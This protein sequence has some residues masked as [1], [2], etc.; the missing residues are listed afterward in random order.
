M[1]EDCPN[2]KADIGDELYNFFVSGGS[3]WQTWYDYE[4]P[5]CKT[6]LTIEVRQEP[7]FIIKAR[8][9]E[10]HVHADTGRATVDSEFDQIV[11]DTVY[12]EGA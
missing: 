2:C 6:I 3:D 8:D 1:F 9:A 4:C 7:S 12:G 5:K 11:E 10:Q